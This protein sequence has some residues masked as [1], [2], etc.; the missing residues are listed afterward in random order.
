MLPGKKVG[1]KVGGVH[2][3]NQHNTVISTARNINVAMRCV[4]RAQNALAAGSPPWTRWGALTA[5]PRPPSW[6]FLR[7]EKKS[8]R[9]K[10][11]KKRGKRKRCRTTAA[12][13]QRGG[14]GV[15]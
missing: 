2:L 15:T 13:Y 8:G 6:I 1:V 3:T 14:V 7:G 11:E 5:L 12:L 10:E 9:E 4:L